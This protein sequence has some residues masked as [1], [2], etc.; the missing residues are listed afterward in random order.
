M[1]SNAVGMKLGFRSGLE[2][3]I[4][5]TMDVLQ[6]PY[7]YEK[8][9]IS[10]LIPASRHTYLPDFILLD[11]GIVVESKGRFVQEDRQ[12]HELIKDQYRWLDIR[13]VFSNPNQKISTKSK[14][15]YASWCEK[16]GFL[17]A[18]KEIPAEWYLEEP[19]PYLYLLK[20]LIEDG[21]KLEASYY[22]YPTPKSS[23]TS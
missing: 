11:N 16:R 23:K 17:Y 9:K 3:D 19:K 6:V 4:S 22:R 20:Q 2:K 8:L 13:F 5:T 1:S 12:K 21:G 15:T 18:S 14:T 7:A 10:Y